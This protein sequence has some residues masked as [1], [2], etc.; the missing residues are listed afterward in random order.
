MAKASFSAYVLVKI[1]LK[2]GEKVH[3]STK[4][5]TTNFGLPFLFIPFSLFCLEMA[6]ICCFYLAKSQKSRQKTR[7]PPQISNIYAILSLKR[8]STVCPTSSTSRHLG[9][10]VLS[11]GLRIGI[12]VQEDVSGYRHTIACCRKGLRRRPLGCRKWGCNKWGF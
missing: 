5:S 3:F 4:K 12:K 1:L 7:P 11:S 2:T 6:K 8:Q 9:S 10:R